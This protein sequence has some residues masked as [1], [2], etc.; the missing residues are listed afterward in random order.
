[1]SQVTSPFRLAAAF[2]DALAEAPASRS[3]GSSRSP[4]PRFRP[5]DLRRSSGPALVSAWRATRRVASRAA[6]VNRLPPLSPTWSTRLI[7]FRAPVRASRAVKPRSPAPFALQRTDPPRRTFAAACANRLPPAQ[8][9][10]S[11]PPSVSGFVPPSPKLRRPYRP[12]SRRGS[13][14]P[15]RAPPAANRLPPAQ[16]SHQT[17]PLG[18]ISMLHQNPKSVKPFSKPILRIGKIA[19]K[20]ALLA[21]FCGIWA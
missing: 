19:H 8:P 21:I 13:A 10:R 2:R 1:M 16:P 12:S 4:P 17:Q 18:T 3:R 6:C 11:P 15:P 14:S 9:L 7:R 20:T 5:R